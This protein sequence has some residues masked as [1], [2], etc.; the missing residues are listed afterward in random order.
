MKS[1]GRTRSG[2]VWLIGA[3]WLMSVHIL[4]AAEPE[5]DPAAWGVY[6]RLPGTDFAGYGERVSWRW[7]PDDTIVEK[8]GLMRTTVI[9]KGEQPGELVSVYNGGLY[10]FDGRIASDGSVTWIRR[11]NFLKMPSRVSI[12]EGRYVEDALKLDKDNQIERVASTLR[13]EQ[14]QGPSVTQEPAAPMIASAPVAAAEAPAPAAATP[15]PQSL[16]TT[17]P[18][19][20]ATSQASVTT[21]QEPKSGPRNLSAAEL[22]TLRQRIEGDKVR[23]AQ[24]LTREQQAAEQQRQQFEQQQMAALEEAQ[25]WEEEA[26]AP[27]PNLAAVFL[28][29]LNSEMAKHQAEREAQDAFIRDVQRQQRVIA[30]RR[31]YEEERQR[32][33]A[34]RVRQQQYAQASQSVPSSA[35]TAQDAARQASQTRVTEARE[36]ELVTQAAAERA[37]QQQLRAQQTQQT[38]S[39]PAPSKPAASEATLKPL[40]FILSISLQNKPDDTV[41]P[42]CYSNVITRPGPPGWGGTGFLPTGS[43]DQAYAAVHALKDAFIARCRASGREIS[44]EG[45]FSYVWNRS[46]GEEAKM[47]NARPRFRED[48]AVSL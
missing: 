12:V 45:N 31:Q 16:P 39:S 20:P 18:I 47:Q 15:P 46:A 29:T 1:T 32:H 22:A 28:N 48:V 27:A 41:N 38:A 40:R 34:E 9:R 23:R 21:A 17:A 36:R 11:G 10:T 43:D 6:A 5:A 7:G 19:V 37:R 3:M 2:V 30:E 35:Q 25:Y 24:A 4:V 42:T 44:S 26:P 33:E 8:R 13:L 14:T